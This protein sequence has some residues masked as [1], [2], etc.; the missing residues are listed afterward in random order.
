MAE[1]ADAATVIDCA[2]MLRYLSREMHEA[3]VG[4]TD[5]LGTVVLEDDGVRR[6]LSIA[7]LLYL[8]AVRLDGRLSND[9]EP[10]PVPKKRSRMPDPEVSREDCEQIAA[11]VSDLFPTFER[12]LARTCLALYDREDELLCGIAARE[13]KYQAAKAEAAR[14]TEKFRAAR[15][16]RDALTQEVERLRAQREVGDA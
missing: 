13:R 11:G 12:R 10:P 6:S 9:Q 14:M 1:L 5:V 4:S 15:A 8:S 2:E 3:G 7:D 16:E